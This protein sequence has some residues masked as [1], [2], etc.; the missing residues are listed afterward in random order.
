MSIINW[1][2]IATGN[3]AHSFASDFKY[4]H[5]GRL[6]AVAS[7]SISKATDFCEKYKIKK[8]YGSYEELFSDPE[9]DAVYIATPHNAHFKNASDALK[10]G[11]AVLCEKPITINPSECQQLIEIS[12]ST[13]IY[14]MEAMWTYFLPPVLKMK[15]WITERRIGKVIHVKAEFGFKADYEANGRLFSPDL[16]GGALLDIGIYPIA[17]TCLVYQAIPN[18][19]LVSSTMAATGVDYEETMIFEYDGAI[20]NLTASLKFKMPNEAV[21]IGEYGY[22]KIPDFFM[23]RECYLYNNDHELLE[24]FTD[25]RLG[26]GYNYQV[27]AVN[28]DLHAG[29]KQS[30]MVPL[31][32]SLKLQEI[33]AIVRQKF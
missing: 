30:E 31:S 3:I 13:N 25:D 4:S 32:T 22:I 18:Q 6:L 2:I 7:R 23:A 26:T 24:H 19:I 5:G 29:K 33:M 8:A 11:K 27:D 17:L 20:A 21:I 15:K 16:A 9:I 10:S 12:K 1:G 28:R 14:L